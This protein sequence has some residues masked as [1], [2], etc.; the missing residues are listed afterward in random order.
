M[1]PVKTWP[2]L[3]PARSGSPTSAA[4]IS[5]RAQHSLLVLPEL[6]GAPPVR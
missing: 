1:S 4:T 6:D 5:E 2:R 3:T